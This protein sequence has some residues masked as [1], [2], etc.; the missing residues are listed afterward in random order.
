MHRAF[1]LAVL[2]AALL[3]L[4]FLPVDRL[5][6]K[7]RFWA[8]RSLPAGLGAPAA[9]QSFVRMPDGVR[10]ATD[11]YLPDAPGPRPTVLVRLPYGKDRFGD[12]FYWIDVF[13]A[14]GYAVVAQDMRGRY[15]SE[16]EFALYRHEQADA[17]A[18]LD[19]IA[20]QPWS[21]GRVGTVGCS[22]LGETQIL[23]AA[24]RHPAHRAM[25]P[26][27]AGGAA[28]ALDGRASYFGG[29]EGGILNLASSFGW[30]SAAGGKT[31]DRMDAPYVDYATALPG[32]PLLSMVARVRPD[33][34]DW[35]DFVSRFADAAWWKA[36]GFIDG[37]E[38][39]ATPGLMVDT[40]Y[41]PSIGGS[42][43][44][45]AK[46]RETAP[47]QH[48]LIAPGT[49]CNH[50]GAA[51]SG[52]VGDTPVGP[53]AMLPFESLFVDFMGHYLQDLPAPELP[54]YLYYVLV[55]DRWREAESWPPEGTERREF[56][57]G[58]GG[59]TRSA[60]GDGR[61][62]ETPGT[63]AT[64]SIVSDPADPVPSIGGAICCTGALDDRAGPRYQDEVEARQDVLVYTSDPG[65][66]DLLIAGP[67]SARLFVS[68][69]TPD[70]DI[71]AR[72]SDVGPDGRSRMIQEGALRLRWRD[73]FAAPNLMQPGE[74]V[75]AEVDMRHIAYLLQAGHR[76][77]LTLAG[78]SFPRLERNLNTGGR[79]YDETEGRRA[80]L[81]LH[82]G[83]GTPSAL[84]MFILS[85]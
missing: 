81:T 64:D 53:E 56:L 10:L 11:V 65:D 77:R 48:L 46:M 44:L 85:E 57:L 41:D 82:T 14:R 47:E 4:G 54:P 8:W 5:P 2:L 18:T 27:G 23:L 7:A 74:V 35:E 83:S 75:E 9:Q 13:V 59:D 3:T 84:T 21:N 63:A 72:L 68:T 78:S 43:A 6:E 31:G 67:L 38:S 12:V 51:G 34:T 39:F 30:F 29:Y 70:A 52:A 22:A 32:L 50:S 60:A 15:A 69:D 20:A 80:T 17:M 36:A 45:T 37:S 66:S 19:W 24:G 62:L 55:E 25:I 28:G 40:W 42:F 76:L 58:S 49:H 26:L 71:V 16:G 79:N 73:G 33:A 61:L 1:P